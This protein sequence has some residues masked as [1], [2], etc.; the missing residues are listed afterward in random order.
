MEV[1]PR[2][3]QLERGAY[4]LRVG[5]DANGDEKPDDIVHR[6]TIAVDGPSEAGFSLPSGRLRSAPF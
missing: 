6:A 1:S 3:W 4:E 2:F 5:P